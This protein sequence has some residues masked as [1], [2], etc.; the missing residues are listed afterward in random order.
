MK[1]SLL[2][3]AFLGILLLGPISGSGH[4]S[5]IDQ[6]T[7]RAGTK[8]AGTKHALSTPVAAAL[9]AEKSDENLTPKEEQFA[10]MSRNEVLAALFTS[11]NEELSKHFTPP[12]SKAKQPVTIEFQIRD[13]KI[14][15]V[16]IAETSGDSRLD[17][18]AKESLCSL[19]IPEG[20][21]PPMH[22]PL[23]CA[24][25]MGKS[26]EGNYVYLNKH[27]DEY[28]DQV[29]KIL[30]DQINAVWQAPDTDG[31]EFMTLEVDITP[32]GEIKDAEIIE[33]QATDAY[34]QSCLVAL[35]SAS[36][37]KNLPAGMPPLYH[38][39]FK[40]NSTPRARR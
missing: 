27:D 38:I 28:F 13:Y 5:K 35:K 19:T 6:I 29:H 4:F 7:E 36:P 21:R 26:G 40:F 12:E 15:S 3:A 23:S 2:S 17:R 8:H 25:S 24:A 18:R 33:Y 34:R 16:R 11:L 1:R 14:S 32:Q 22:I 39:E 10:R 31:T 9:A 37:L 30:E 20:Q